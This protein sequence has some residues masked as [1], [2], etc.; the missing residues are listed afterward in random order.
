MHYMFFSQV[1]EE[2]QFPP[3]VTP[4]EV[5]VGSWQDRWEGGSLGHVHATDQDQ[6]DTLA[7]YI[8]NYK[9]LFKI[10]ERSGEIRAPQ[11]LDAGYYSINVSISDGKFLSFSTVNVAVDSL[12]DDMLHEAISIRYV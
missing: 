6:Y 12:A 10:D 9:E 2:S 5:W 7:Y 11:G 4:L 1:I 8:M 3:V